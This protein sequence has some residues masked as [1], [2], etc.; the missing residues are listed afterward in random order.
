MSLVEIE[1]KNCH[2][3]FPRNKNK[4]NEALK[5]GWNQYCSLKCQFDARLTGEHRFCQQCTKKI[6]RFPKEL[7]ASLTNRFFCGPS[8][9]AKFNNNL[10]SEALPKNYCTYPSCTKE[11]PRAHLYCSRACAAFH[12]R[13]S[14]EVLKK[15]V[16][17]KIK[18]FERTNGRIPVKQEMYDIYKKARKVYGTWNKAITAAGFQP[19]PVMFSKKYVSRD[20]HMCDSL[21]EKILD[22]WLYSKEIPHER[23]VHYPEETRMTCDF[24]V[25][26][27]FIEFFGLDG[28]HKEYSRL[29]NRKRILAKKYNLN[30]IEVLPKDIFPKNHLDQKLAF[31]T[32]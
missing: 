15:E 13:K 24:Q 2:Q 1:C 20:G 27:Y 12:K 3:N 19:N 14:K 18:N 23:S 28:K 25:G 11:I 29:A 30:L 32:R 21:A 16:L 7:K 31:L 22:E 6:W 4:A 10:R 26:K 9:A 5:F 8:C 17:T